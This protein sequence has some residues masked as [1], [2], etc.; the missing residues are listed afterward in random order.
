MLFYGGHENV[1]KSWKGK[2]FSIL[3]PASYPPLARLSKQSRAHKLFYSIIV[4]ENKGK[5]I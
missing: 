1:V 2:V 3:G 5:K 4:E